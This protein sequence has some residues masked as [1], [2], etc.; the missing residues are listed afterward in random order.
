LIAEL[1]KALSEEKAARSAAD[2]ALVEEKAAQQTDEQSLLSSNEV[3]TLL[4]KELDST[5]TSLTATTDK[6][7]SK[8]SALD[9]SVIQEQQL[10]I[11]LTVCEEKL[12]ACEE[13]LTVANNKLKATEEKMKT[14]GQLLD[15]AQQALSRWE[16]SSL[17]V[18]SS[19]VANVVALIKN[20]LLD[21]DVEILHKDFTVDDV[22]REILVNS[23]Y[24]VAH[25]FVSLYNF[26]SLAES[27]DNNSL[28]AL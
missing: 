5:R 16:L 20:H 25:D 19:A 8:S 18:I 14:Q 6:L 28:G 10:K 7:S 26:F 9:H 22:D 24:D 17:A 27:N 1:K 15:L 3:N 23:T 4:A 21:L 12:T 13:R 11:R 2:W